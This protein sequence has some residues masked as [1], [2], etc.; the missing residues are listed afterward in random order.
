MMLVVTMAMPG[1]QCDKKDIALLGRPGIAK[2][3]NS[4]I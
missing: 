4:I 2:A 1:T 3:H